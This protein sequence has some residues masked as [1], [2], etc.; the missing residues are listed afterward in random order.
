MNSVILETPLLIVLYGVALIVGVISTKEPQSA[1]LP[2]SSLVL[3]VL[4]SGFALFK[5]ASLYEIAT[6]L[7]AFLA[8]NL[9][10]FKQRGNK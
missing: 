1:L 6:V 3:C 2:F 7:L 8:L 10:V 4:T 5:G 9:T